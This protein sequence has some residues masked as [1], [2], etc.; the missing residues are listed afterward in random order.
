VRCAFAVHH[1]IGGSFHIDL[2]ENTTARDAWIAIALGMAIAIAG[3][4]IMPASGGGLAADSGTYIQMAKGIASFPEGAIGRRSIDDPSNNFD[5]T[6]PIGFPALIFAFT[7]TGL[8]PSTSA[9]LISLLAFVLTGGL[10]CL[11]VY[12]L[13]GIEVG[14]ISTILLC[15][16]CDLV[17]TARMGMSELPA[18]CLF[19]CGLAILDVFCSFPSRSTQHIVSQM[20]DGDHRNDGQQG[21]S[22]LLA[23]LFAG[24]AFGGT[25]WLRYAML[26]VVG[27]A[28]L[29]AFVLQVRREISRRAAI[30]V[31]ATATTS[32]GALVGINIACSGSLTGPHRSVGEQGFFKNAAT[33]INHIS[34]TV[35]G[36]LGSMTSPITIVIA[37]S[38]ALIAGI[39]LIWSI[40]MMDR[41]G[42]IRPWHWLTGCFLVAY[43]A[44]IV[45]TSTRVNYDPISDRFL[46]PWVFA[47]YLC[48]LSPLTNTVIGAEKRQSGRLKRTVAGLMLLGMGVGN[49]VRSEGTAVVHGEF[50]KNRSWPAMS[51][52]DLLAPVLDEVRARNALLI[53]NDKDLYYIASPSE[54]LFFI[55]GSYQTPL[56]YLSEDL[57]RHLAATRE[58][59]LLLYIQYD[60]PG[61]EARFTGPL[62][63]ILL[64]GRGEHFA[65]LLRD[66]GR[67]KLFLHQRLSLPLKR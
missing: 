44:F 36:Y 24:F 22:N 61:F 18:I 41:S 34:Q 31:I 65:K 43:P 13:Y 2:R 33:L 59:D 1:H 12:R 14:V 25:F 35:F 4:F 64:S 29:A 62:T 3:Y 23:A 60:A 9:L 56:R 21:Q 19:T 28:I 17:S 5:T 8:S 51:E 39:I 46:A 16:A 15:S 27:C 42:K 49:L 57:V 11:L 30:A 67:G 32:A 53:T 50:M 38:L 54:D 40:S 63:E 6:F 7:S 20:S 55:P 37:A 45:H 66:D 48:V 47:Y 26:P 10:A 58:R 52:I